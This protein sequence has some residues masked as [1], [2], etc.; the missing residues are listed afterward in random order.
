MSDE[1]GLSRRSVVNV[2]QAMTVDKS[3]LEQYIGSLSPRRIR[4]VVAG[5]HL[6]IDP[7]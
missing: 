5:I 4:E 1:G 7:I 6:I 2:S 3:Q